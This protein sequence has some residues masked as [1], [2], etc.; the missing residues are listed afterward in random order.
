MVEGSNVDDEG[1]YR[2][3]L[4]AIA[5]LDI[6]SPLRAAK[7]TKAEIRALSEEFDLPT[8]NKPSYACLASRF[9]YGELITKEKLALVDKGEQLLY[10]LGFKQFRVRIHGNSNFVAR[11]E[12]LPEDFE[13]LMESELRDKI[14]AKFKSFGF[15]YTSLDLKGYRTGSM[16]ETL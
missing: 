15:A 16:N 4:K 9:P 14:S 10:D 11:I 13:R 6:K 5:E 8:Y 1:D 12:L 7:L 3:G 2:P